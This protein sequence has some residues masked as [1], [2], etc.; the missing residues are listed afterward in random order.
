MKRYAH[1]SRQAKARKQRAAKRYIPRR[2]FGFFSD[3][4]VRAVKAA[5][6]FQQA[7]LRLEASAGCASELVREVEEGILALAEENEVAG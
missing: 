2:L 3:V 5:S 7:M 1:L 4:T 6:D